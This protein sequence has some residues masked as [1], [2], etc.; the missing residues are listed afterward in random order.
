MSVYVNKQITLEKT[1]TIKNE[2]FRDTGNIGDI[3]HRTY[4]DKAKH[5]QH[6]NLR[7]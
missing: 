2:K 4:T 5:V 7:R 6:R 3:R 1:K